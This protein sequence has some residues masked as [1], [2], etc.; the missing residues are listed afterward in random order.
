MPEQF[1]IANAAQKIDP[2]VTLGLLSNA[3]FV[4]AGSGNQELD[5]RFGS[6]QSSN[7]E[8]DPLPAVKAAWHE[9]IIELTLLETVQSRR[10]IENLRFDSVE[11]EQPLPDFFA[12]HK[13]PSNVS[14]RER[15]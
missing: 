12:D 11:L 9:Q 6:R 8:I 15:R 10:L 14:A 4:V 1:V 13:K 3:G 7:D 2:G 5:W